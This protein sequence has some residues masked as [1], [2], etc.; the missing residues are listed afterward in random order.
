MS[1]WQ[2]TLKKGTFEDTAFLILHFTNIST[3][4]ILQQVSQ[5]RLQ[6]RKQ[7]SH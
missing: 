5:M 7:N 1:K 3:Q 4:N 6:V 2:V